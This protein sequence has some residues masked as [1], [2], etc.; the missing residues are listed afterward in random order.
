MHQTQPNTTLTALI[1]MLDDP[2]DRVFS[3]IANQLLAMGK[4]A[5]VP[6]EAALGNCFDD[7]ITERIFDLLDRLY[8][9]NLLA[10]FTAWL[11]TENEDLLKGFIIISQTGFRNIDEVEISALVAQIKTDVWIELHDDLTAM[12]NVRVINHVLYKIHGFD[13]NRRDISDPDN[14]YINKLLESKKGN[15]LSLG[16]LYLIIARQLGLPV[17]GVDLP[18]HF[19]LAYLKSDNITNPDENDVLFYINPFNNG[20][21]FTRREIDQFLS[22]MKIKPEKSFYQP[23]SNIEVIRKLIN[24]LVFSYTN[25][26]IHEKLTELENLLNAFP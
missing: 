19:I 20:A 14:S 16:M 3:A 24:N 23:C 13:G 9:A 5:I 4:D 21:I 22:Q 2:D 17:F 7:Q 10:N 12:E 11:Q 1:K 6:L 26:G 15:P 25:R 8:Q 18:Q